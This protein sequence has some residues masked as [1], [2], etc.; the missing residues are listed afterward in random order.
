MPPDAQVRARL[1]TSSK[2]LTRHLDMALGRQLGLDLPPR[3]PARRVS[4]LADSPTAASHSL[5]F[6]ADSGAWDHTS[7]E[8]WLQMDAMRTP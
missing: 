5:A 7:I 2:C 6:A 3:S 4:A 8:R 1:A